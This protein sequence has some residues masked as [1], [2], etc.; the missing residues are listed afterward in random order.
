MTI[1]ARS[2]KNGNAVPLQWPR[3][4]EYARG[5]VKT[6]VETISASKPMYSPGR[7]LF[8]ES[9]ADGLRRP[10][11]VRSSRCRAENRSVEEYTDDFVAKVPPPQ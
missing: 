9:A 8:A 10:E 6:Y 5:N 11:A 3:L 7:T 4:P 1:I 2:H